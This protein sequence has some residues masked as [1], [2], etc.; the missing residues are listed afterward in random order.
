MTGSAAY[1]R[2]AASALIAAMFMG[3]TLVTP[4]YAI[5]AERFGFSKLV[6]TLIYAVYVVGNLAA[7][8]LFGRVSD[9]FGRRRTALPAI[10]VALASTLVFLFTRSTA[11]LFA[12]RALSGLAIGVASAAGTAWLADVEPE[13][14]RPRAALLATSANFIGI[15]LGPL[16]AGLLAEYAPAPLR[17]SYVVYLLVIVAVGI[18]VA[19]AREPDAE[20]SGR[21]SLRPRIGVARPIR[22]AFVAP[23]ITAFCTFGFIGF[24]AALAPSLIGERLH[25]TSHAL[26]GAV[27]FELFL[28]AALTNFATR[29]LSSRAAMR[30]GLAVQLPALGLLVAADRLASLP[31]LLG[32]TAIAGASAALGYRGSLQVVN[33]LAPPDRRGETVASYMIACFV[34][35]SLPVIG[36]ALLAAATGSSVT[37]LTVFAATIAALAIAAFLAAHDRRSEDLRSAGRSPT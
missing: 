4:L 21:W 9:A 7:L 13:A 2:L 6:L 35:N 10:G 37:A 25:R 11:W 30:A 14:H 34:G 1:A 20:R 26:G 5:Y 28:V 33:A 17:L 22:K 36:V 31:L 16:L 23:A 24:Y 29:R 3:S 18:V 32:A 15:A 12:A 8:L 27:V 19:S